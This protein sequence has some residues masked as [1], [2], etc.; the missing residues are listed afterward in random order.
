MNANP[1]IELA[2]LTLLRYEA[3]EDF[4]RL[5]STSDSPRHG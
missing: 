4:T 3:K 1:E 5:L 2:Q